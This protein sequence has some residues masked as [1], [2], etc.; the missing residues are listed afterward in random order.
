ML[1]IGEAEY[2]R[3]IFSF[4]IVMW[5]MVSRALCWQGLSSNDIFDL[6]LTRQIRPP[7]TANVDC[8]DLSSKLQSVVE[9]AAK[10]FTNGYASQQQLEGEQVMAKLVE[11]MVGSW[12]HEPMQRLEA[13]LAL[14]MLA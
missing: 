9:V 3:D 10:Y 2:S 11:V 5:E 4:G 14:E 1:S 7:T 12:C 8:K 13:K 6:V